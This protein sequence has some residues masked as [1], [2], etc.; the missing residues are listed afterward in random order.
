MGAGGV[1]AESPI[2]KQV[3]L[4]RDEPV[5]QEVVVN[6]QGASQP[7]ASGPLMVVATSVMKKPPVRVGQIVEGFALPRPV[8]LSVLVAAGTGALIGFVLGLVI[9]GI[10]SAVYGAAILA[11]LGFL[12]VTYSPLAGESFAKWIRLTFFGR[13]KRSAHVTFGG[14]RVRVAV[15]IC[16]VP[17]PSRGE[18]VRLWPG[19]LR[20]P[21]SQYDRRGV[22]LSPKNRNVLEA[23]IAPGLSEW[24]AGPAVSSLDHL[25]EAVL[26]AFETPP[27]HSHPA[28]SGVPAA[29]APPSGLWVPPGMQEGTSGPSRRGKGRSRR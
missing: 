5:V 28:P 6:E 17:R 13:G 9:G 14:E 21:P 4:R 3:L 29:D 18:R 20:V 8:R 7:Q 10:R 1:I 11:A 25:D 2:G 12:L 23:E 26:A 16:P 22:R 27:R 19:S 15:G 24:V